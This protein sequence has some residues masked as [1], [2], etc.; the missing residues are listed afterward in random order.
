M[1]N[2][3][4]TVAH[5]LLADS[6]GQ[7]SV[8][9]LAAA[10]HVEAL[11]LVILE[12]V[13]IDDV[14]LV[15]LDADDLIELRRQWGDA[16]DWL[17]YHRNRTLKPGG[18]QSEWVAGANED[19]AA[20]GGRTFDS[21]ASAKGALTASAAKLAILLEQRHPVIFGKLYGA[22]FDAVVLRDASEG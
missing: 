10:T 19:A 2:Q 7:I 3:F 13:F 18:S 6:S 8:G 20:C 5:A 1:K 14:R 11:E 17:A 12:L 15:L 16:Y 4:P 9:E 22:V 21:W